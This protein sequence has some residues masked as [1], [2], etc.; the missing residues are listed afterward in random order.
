LSVIL[1]RPMPATKW[2]RSFNGEPKATAFQNLH[3]ACDAD[4]CGLP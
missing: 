1:T 3:R 4:A 2:E